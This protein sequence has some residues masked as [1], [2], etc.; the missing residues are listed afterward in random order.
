[1]TKVCRDCKHHIFKGYSDAC[2]ADGT[3]N[4]ITGEA[5]WQLCSTARDTGEPCGP[6][7]KLYEADPKGRHKKSMIEWMV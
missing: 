3:I 5:V 4:K 2:V 7:G 6:F 1:M